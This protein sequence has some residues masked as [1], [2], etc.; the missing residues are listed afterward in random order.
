MR[1]AIYCRVATEDQE[2]EGTSL[3]SQLKACLKRAHELSY[4]VLGIE[5]MKRET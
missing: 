1:V 5:T 4:E 3:E 2:G